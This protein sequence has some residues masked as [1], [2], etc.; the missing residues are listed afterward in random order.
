MKKIRLFFFCALILV[1]PF[2]AQAQEPYFEIDKVTPP[3]ADAPSGLDRD[4][5]Q[6]L[7]E[8]FYARSRDED[9]GAASHL[10]SV[11]DDMEADPATLAYQ[12][13]TILE[14]KALIDWSRLMD[15]PDGLDAM[16]SSD[17]ATAGT[18]RRSILLAL[19]D[20][21]GRPVGIRI[22]RLKLPDA[23]TVW[24]FSS[25][26]VDNVPEL[27]DR[28][29]PSRFEQ[30]L[31]DQLRGLA[32][33]GLRWWEIVALPLLV[34]VAIVVGRTVYRVLSVDGVRVA[35]LRAGKVIR[36]MRSPAVVAAVTTL[37]ALAARHVFVFSGP[38]DLVLMPLLTTGYVIAVLWFLVS[39][40]DAFLDRLVSFQGED[41][42][43]VDEGSEARRQLA[44]NV[45]AA[46]RVVIVIVAIVG[47]GV[48]LS[49]ANVLRT[50]GFSLLASA[51]AIGII[52]AYAARNV[53]SN[54][55][56]SLQIA[57]NKSARIGDRVFY[58][59][60]LCSVERINFTYVQL[61]VWT[62]ERLVVP[63]NDFVSTVF[64]NWTMQDPY[65]IRTVRLRFCHDVKV[66]VLR[67]IY[68]E[69][70]AEIEDQISNQQSADRGVHVSGHDVF[71][72]EV[73]F[74]VPCDEPNTAW[75]TSCDMREL[76]IEKAM[77]RGKEEGWQVFP[78]VSPA[79]VV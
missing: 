5:P 50:M 23:D 56:S 1:L 12:L 6:A 10:L 39:V 33:W 7:I 29:G 70:L 38:I 62:G 49:Q 61:R 41:L 13:F 9:W 22:N 46:R 78:D 4:T 55:M 11:P 42:T 16:A 24:L 69:A 47:F 32:F 19:I 35:G 48:V 60:H 31:P 66:D 28:Y 63:V 21:D 65:V 27:F 67:E 79:E 20:L 40:V 17:S 71:G 58:D 45:A 53:L 77:R 52:L 8:S 74:T 14:R 37:V 54:I 75:V 59:G 3:L 30:V 73:L 76:L 36:A 18:P 44:T 25:Q 26:S 51:G 43:V 2:G 57:M 34:L 64:E 72:K 68:R 15:R